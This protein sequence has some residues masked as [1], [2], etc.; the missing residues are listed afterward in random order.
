VLE[1]LVVTS[2][3]MAGPLWVY[4]TNRAFHVA[5]IAGVAQPAQQVA[6]MDYQNEQE[7][8]NAP[9]ATQANSRFLDSAVAVA[10]AASEGQ[11]WGG[12]V[13]TPSSE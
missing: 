9:V 13:A 10:P 12:A 6:P 8:S 2:M 7:W 11:D 4:R 5:E 3:Y 1:I